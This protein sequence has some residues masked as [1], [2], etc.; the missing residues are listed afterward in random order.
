MQHVYR[1]CER[2]AESQRQMS[3]HYEEAR[4]ERRQE[5][6]FKQR[7][8]NCAIALAGMILPFVLAWVALF[9][10]YMMH[11]LN[12]PAPEVLRTPNPERA[13]WYM[14]C[15]PF[16]LLVSVD[17]WFAGTILWWVY[18]CLIVGGAFALVA[19]ILWPIGPVRKI[20]LLAMLSALVG[21][22]FA[23]PWY[24]A[25]FRRLFLS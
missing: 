5:R 14:V 10:I 15:D 11:E 24:Y 22:V 2:G 3:R 12:R 8:G 1:V 20:K 16:N 21:F 23:L 19:A 13:S 7:V 25:L 18:A 4:N 9:S 17:P 6:A